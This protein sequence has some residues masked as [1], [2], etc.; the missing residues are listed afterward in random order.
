MTL[1]VRLPNPAHNRQLLSRA[2]TEVEQHDLNVTQIQMSQQT[3]RLLVH[4]E[5]D[6]IWTAQVRIVKN[7]PKNNVRLSGVRP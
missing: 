1:Q 3:Q 4:F 2:F 6:V 7:L 5:P